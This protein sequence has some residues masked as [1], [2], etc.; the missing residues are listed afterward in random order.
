MR[1]V[2]DRPA[3][4]ST[5]MPT[6]AGILAPEDRLELIDGDIVGECY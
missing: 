4:A 1:T 6:T 5:S 3:T 2:L